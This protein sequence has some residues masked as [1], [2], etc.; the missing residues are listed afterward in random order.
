MYGVYI[1]FW[2]TL[3]AQ[4]C[5]L[6]CNGS[7][8]FPCRPV[9]TKAAHQ[10]GHRAQPDHAAR[11]GQAHHQ[12][13]RPR[14]AR[15]PGGWLHVGVY[16]HCSLSLH[17]ACAC[18]ILFMYA[19]FCNCLSTFAACYTA[20]VWAILLHCQIRGCDDC[21]II[22]GKWRLS[23][24]SFSKEGPQHSWYIGLARTVYRSFTITSETN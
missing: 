17:S 24:H 10:S 8:T 18:L 1:R 22:I 20:F 6:V 7:L 11:L 23:W 4:H 19:L 15:R 3:H 13:R 5:G 21:K 14:M 16:A 12:C 2:P 9:R